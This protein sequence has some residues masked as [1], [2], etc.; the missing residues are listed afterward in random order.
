MM[1]VPNDNLSMVIQECMHTTVTI[2]CVE[3]LAGLVIKMDVYGV[4]VA[5]LKNTASAQRMKEQQKNKKREINFL[6]S[7]LTHRKIFPHNHTLIVHSVCQEYI[8]I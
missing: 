8:F 1:P 2:A 6:L 4:V 7:Q 3:W 5:N